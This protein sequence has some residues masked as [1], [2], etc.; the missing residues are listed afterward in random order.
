MP[1][2]EIPLPR[3]RAG[4]LAVAALLL[5][6]LGCQPV[7]EPAPPAPV[8]DGAGS[9]QSVPPGFTRFRIV[10][11]GTEVRA[12]VYRD[13][14]MARLG[15]NH[16]V[17]TRALAG[18][19]LLGEPGTEPRLSLQLPVA[20]LTVDEAGLRAEEGVDFPGP[21]PDDAIDGTRR[22]LLGADLLDAERHPVIR[23]TS[24][25]ITGQAPDYAVTVIVEVKGASHE[26]QVP[27]RVERQGD[28]L[29]A[30]GQFTVTHAQ[31]G[32]TPFS[33]MGGLLSVR[34]EIRLKF[35]IL[36]RR[37]IAGAPPRS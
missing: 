20:S 21:V 30:T 32:L 8:P 29:R 22:N 15:H 31:L 10:P 19:V 34:D 4:L 25:A 36:A 33:V 27:V 28:D 37:D 18:E 12:L 23:L 17:S 2:P 7:R 11:A 35:A 16:V 26:L 5:V 6:A 24:G 9:T 14:P 1:L 13:G 3:P